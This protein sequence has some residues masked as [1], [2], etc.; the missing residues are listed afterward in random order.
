MKEDWLGEEVDPA[1]SLIAGTRHL[2]TARKGSYNED[3]G[4]C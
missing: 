2:P 4:G 1:K 3:G